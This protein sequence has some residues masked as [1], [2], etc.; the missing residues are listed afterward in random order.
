MGAALDALLIMLEPARLLIL[1]G[2]VM[3][4]LIVGV[5]PGLSGVVGLAILIPFTYGLD[6]YAA[7]A[8]LI[9]MHAVTT[10]SDLI[11][12]VLF[13]VPGTVGAAATVV[14]GHQMAKKGEAGRAFGAGY[15]ASLV[16]GLAGALLLAIMIPVIRPL[17]LYLGSPELLAFAVFGLSMVAVLSGRA[18]LK[19]LAG[20]AIGILIAMVGYTPQSGTLRWTNDLVYLWEGLPLVPITLGLFAIPEILDLVVR[21]SSVASGRGAVDLGLASQWQGVRD[22]MIHWKL[23]LRSSWMGTLL[24]AVPG[25][26]SASIDWIVYGQAQRSAKPPNEF[27]RGDVRGVIAPESAVNAKE[28]GALVPTIAFGVPG[29]ASMAVLLSAFLLHGLVPGP[30]MLGENLDVTYSI[31]WSLAL[32]NILATAVCLTLSGHFARISVVTPGKLV[33]VV[34]AFIVVGA[35]QGTSN[36][37]D[38]YV[39]VIF[40]IFGWIMK[41]N[42]W[43][44]PPIMLGF[45]L[46]TLF[47]RYMFISVQ[48]FGWQWMLRPIVL[49]ILAA[50]VWVMFKPLKD[51]LG[52]TLHDLRRARVARM[53]PGPGALTSVAIIIGLVVLLIDAGDWPASARLVPIT[54]IG[55]ALVMTALNLVTELFRPAEGPEPA[56]A[57]PASGTAGTEATAGDEPQGRLRH[58]RAARFL[59][60][61]AG[62]LVSTLV[63]GL[64]PTILVMTFLLTLV[65]FRERLRTALV[66]TALATGFMWVC[67]DQVF[68]VRWPQSVLGDVLP[69]LR[70]AT[71]LF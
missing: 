37:G 26:G 65:E 45:V 54:A 52:S 59:A 17:V 29:G 48:I 30:K 71:G 13:G 43:P 31:V 21:R 14:D 27:G 19:G 60:W 61:L 62:Y 66:A 2:G 32:A 56:A 64:L 70:Q 40:G 18:P 51:S 1:C 3:L 46:G 15:G 67:F 8:L 69:A 5:I 23:A 68:G 25:L 20:A 38:L 49:I 36:V 44:R 24:G 12:A 33:P 9:G 6:P 22:V 35:Y 50:A 53:R 57:G 41:E 10:N 34:V 58:A 11:P 7:F 28:G 16:G 4:G 63:I 39:L 47:E 55:V 42:G